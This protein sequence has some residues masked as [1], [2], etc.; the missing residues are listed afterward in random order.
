M[1]RRRNDVT[2]V[3]R[4]TNLRLLLVFIVFKD[5]SWWLARD[6]QTRREP[7]LTKRRICKL[8]ADM[9]T[10]FGFERIGHSGVE[11]KTSTNVAAF[12]CHF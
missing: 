6:Q 12:L 7:E 3:C 8:H 10:F 5:A 2:I 9:R 4:V 1:A 11:R